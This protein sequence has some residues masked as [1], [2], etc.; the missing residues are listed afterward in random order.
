MSNHL[1][2]IGKLSNKKPSEYTED[3]IEKALTDMLNE[4][5]EYQ[6]QEYSFKVLKVDKE[7]MK[8]TVEFNIVFEDN[9]NYIGFQG[10]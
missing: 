8:M 3:E 5:L 9:D 7:R 6:R 10:Y 1:V 4:C 2:R